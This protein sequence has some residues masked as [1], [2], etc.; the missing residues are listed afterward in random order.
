MMLIESGDARSEQ[1]TDCMRT[2]AKTANESFK[3]SSSR[4]I[5]E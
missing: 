4:R 3:E 1:V 5:D 2:A